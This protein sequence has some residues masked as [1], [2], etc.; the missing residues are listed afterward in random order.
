MLVD[1]LRPRASDKLDSEIVERSDLSLESNS[2]RQ[3]DSDFHSVIAEVLQ[4]DVLEA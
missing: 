2:V 3:K 4:E 1:D